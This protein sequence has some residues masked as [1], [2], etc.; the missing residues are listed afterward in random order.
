MNKAELNGLLKQYKYIIE[1][2][3]YIN[4]YLRGQNGPHEAEH[5]ANAIECFYNKT[6][7]EALDAF[8]KSKEI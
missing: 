4:D 5:I 3:E 2:S 1:L 7:M 6:Y 8:E